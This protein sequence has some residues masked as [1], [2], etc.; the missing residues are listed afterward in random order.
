MATIWRGAAK[1]IQ[2]AQYVVFV[3]YSFPPTDTDMRYFLGRSLL[4]NAQLRKIMVV[5]PSASE[6]VKR[7][8]GTGSG[9]GSHFRAF[10]QAL[11]DDW[12]N[13]G[14]PFSI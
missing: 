1:A 3:G 11:E 9:Y 13:V 2:S 12:T 4:G 8:C 14:L 7:L 6:I 10:L 5:D